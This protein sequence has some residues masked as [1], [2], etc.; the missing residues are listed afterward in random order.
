V[1]TWQ[2]VPAYLAGA[3]YV[4][5]PNNDR[6][7]GDLS[8]DVAVSQASFLY[9]WFDT[10][11]STPSWVT[12]G[13]WSVTGSQI[14]LGG[15]SGETFDIWRKPLAA[16]ANP[17]VLGPAGASGNAMYG[18]GATPLPPVPTGMTTPVAALAD[19]NRLGVGNTGLNAGS[20]Q[21]TIDPSLFPG[22]DVDL[23]EDPGDLGGGGIAYWYVKPSDQGGSA[24]LPPKSLYYDLGQ[25][26]T[27]DQIHLWWQNRDNQQ[28][29]TG[30]PTDMD[31]DYIALGD[32]QPGAFDLATMQAVTNWTTAVAGHVPTLDM[33]GI[34]QTLDLPDFSTQYIR[35]KMNSAYLPGGTQQWGGLRQ[36]ALDVEPLAVIPEPSTF[37]LW[38]LGLLS[39]GWYGRRR[40]R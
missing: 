25:P 1:Y 5:T 34:E 38:S 6:G 12:G 33:S 10:R 7:D 39:L 21:W 4:Q 31:I 15:S 8:I 11:V 37:L 18:F 27:V 3:D 24:A 26:M 22:G 36:I 32:T 14:S 28:T 40:R 20:V 17:N 19:L 35:L 9:A 30:L 23:G 13:G 16:G 2:T 29:T